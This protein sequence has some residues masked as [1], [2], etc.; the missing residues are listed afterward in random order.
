MAKKQNR[1]WFHGAFNVKSSVLPKLFVR[2]AL[3][4]IIS[5]I[6]SIL[7]FFKLPVSLPILGALVPNI[8]L[9]LLLVFRT[10]TA[11]ERFWEGRK[12][13]GEI[14]NNIRSLAIDI[15]SLNLTLEQKQK[16]GK[17]LIQFAELT[18]DKFR[19]EVS[20]KKLADD[21]K[22]TVNPNL[23]ELNQFNKE[24]IAYSKSGLFS[25][26]ICDLINR[27]TSNLIN[28]VGGCERIIS[29]PIPLGYSIH[30]KQLILLYSLTLPFQ[31]V[32]QAGIFTPLICF[33]IA[34]ALMGIEE[35]G[36]EIENPFGKDRNDIKLDKICENIEKNV[37]ELIY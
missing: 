4:T 14:N 20:A 23:W 34:F 8:I 24:I 31:F 35:I 27:K 21:Q 36:I 7:Y 30:I 9:G 17:R 33:F 18:K 6:V 11:Y 26:I 19:N 32:A 12:L 5:I 1:E 10:N 22:N 2:L 37:L 25:D 28:A 29:T 15:N 13:W 3:V 16:L